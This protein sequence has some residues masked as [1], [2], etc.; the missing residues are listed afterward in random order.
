MEQTT[1]ET[2]SLR[3]CVRELA[4][5]SVLSAA[6]GLT[7][8]QGIAESLVE[9]LLRSL[10]HVDFVYARVKALSDD[11]FFEAAHTSQP[12]NPTSRLQEIGKAVEA[13]LSNSN[14]DQSSVIPNPIGEGKVRL[15]VIPIGYEGDC[16][17]L[18]AG[19][20]QPDFPSPTDKLLL[21]VAANQAAVVLQHHRSE[22]T[23][24]R[25]SRLLYD[26]QKALREA[27]ESLRQQQ[28]L[29][30]V[31]LASIGDAVIVL[32]AV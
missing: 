22:E 15:A 14:S 5:L 11:G 32:I 29:L 13:L 16:G 26:E 10:L 2:R 30:R 27:Q 20:Q 19:S 23:L 25:Q 6:W 7:R 12:P 18:V 3:R 28:E 24:R 31:T 21:D 4:A 8:P 1:D 17:V 9:V